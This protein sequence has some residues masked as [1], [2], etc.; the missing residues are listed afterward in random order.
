[1]ALGLAA[2]AYGLAA[3]GGAS[4][5]SLA[6][7][8]K[9]EARDPIRPKPA[10][11]TYM[12]APRSP[13]ADRIPACR[14][15]GPGYNACMYKSGY[16]VNPQWIAAHNRDGADANSSRMPAKLETINDAYRAGAGSAYG[17]PYW[18]PAPNPGL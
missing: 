14:R 5:T 9:R 2:A 3:G 11:Q 6:S 12:P 8:F 18:V 13:L 10:P 16:V 4:V 15:Q 1:M 7:R 17:V